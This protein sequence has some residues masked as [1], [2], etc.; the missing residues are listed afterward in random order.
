MS[1]S[2]IRIVL[3]QT[4]HP[5]NIGSVARAMKTMGLSDLWLVAPKKL[6]EEQARAMASGADDVLAAARVVET[7]PEAIADC[8]QVVGTSARSQRSVDW[9]VLSPRATAVEAITLAGTGSKV[10]LVFGRESSGLT[11]EELDYCQ[12]LV[13]IPANA[14]Y[15]SLNLAAAV[16][17]LVYECRVAQ[18]ALDDAQEQSA[19]IALPA[20]Q[21]DSAA[22]VSNPDDPP[23][24]Q[25]EVEG[26]YQHLEQLMIES[27]FLNPDN[28]RYLMRR[29]R[30][31]YGRAELLSS[32]VSL[33][34]GAL[35]A[36]QGRKF[37]PRNQR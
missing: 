17:I 19:N 25:R 35:S 21:G 31:L 11:N 26:V 12:H 4:S 28:P 24:S 29:M 9:S 10:A 16:Q 20:A 2:N 13:H 14:E 33:L 1:L 7:L 5:G 30:R 22:K 34:R 27:S 37:Q 32:E 3:I 8:H 36:F 6:P 23:A 18:L 15:S